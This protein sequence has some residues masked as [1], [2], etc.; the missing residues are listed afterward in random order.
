MVNFEEKIAFKQDE[1]A[2]PDISEPPLI[3]YHI[4]HKIQTNLKDTI[5]SFKYLSN[6]NFIMKIHIMKHLIKNS[7][8]RCCQLS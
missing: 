8:V 3:I 6:F 1:E 2:L 5:M 7:L 4:I